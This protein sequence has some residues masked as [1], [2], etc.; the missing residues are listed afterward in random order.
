MGPLSHAEIS[1]AV[2]ARP[3]IMVD[4]LEDHFDELDFLWEH[5]E[6]SVFDFDYDLAGL[7]EVEERALA[8]LEG[9]KL[10]GD[11]SAELAASQLQTDSTSAA[12]AAVFTLA[13]L[14]RGESVEAIM[15]AFVSKGPEVR[16]GI[17]IALR[18]VEPGRFLA[19]LREHAG[20]GDPACGAAA[21][22][23][24]AFHRDAS[25]VV[26]QEWL[27]HE[28]E[29]V[30]RLAIGAIGRS[31]SGSFGPPALESAIESEIRVLQRTALETAARLGLPNLVA[32]CRRLASRPEGPVPEALVFLGVVGEADDLALLTHALGRENLAAAALE[33]L[34]AL[35]NTRAVPEL[36]AAMRRP[37]LAHAAGAAFR[38]I[39]GVD[40]VDADEPL[41]LPEGMSEDEADF[42]EAALPPDPE[43][44]T[45]WWEAEESNF[46][47]EGR[48]Q[49]GFEVA[50]D[51][52]GDAFDELPLPCRRD[53]Y[54]RACATDPENAPVL[55]LEQRAGLQTK[56]RLAG[57]G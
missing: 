12:T 47:V 36:I 25:V 3:A 50:A 55:E 19:S 4:L 1:M 38:R 46:G 53:V 44:A 11:H 13:A 52:F 14:G 33:G 37:E 23:V 2:A 31:R 9:L 18:H 22:D 28:D 24:L 56:A 21:L 39:T 29:T 43:R 35:G 8:H 27:V 54:L 16:E 10:G 42:L 20:S 32:I 26:P 40:D 7:A 15:E 5:R 57:K 49:S 30:R 41:P 34:G 45:Q 51:P 48:W 6:R 17:R